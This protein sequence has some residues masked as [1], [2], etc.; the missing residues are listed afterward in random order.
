MPG[1]LENNLRRAYLQ[2]E[3][4]VYLLRT[5]AAVATIERPQD[6]GIDAIATLLRQS[7]TRKLIAEDTFFVQLKAG[8][9]KEVV[10]DEAQLTWYRQLELPYFI[11]SV[12]PQL[13]ELS[14]Y[15]CFAID[16]FFSP[17]NEAQSVTLRL[18]KAN[19]LSTYSPVDVTRVGEP[20][21]VYLGEPL[22]RFGLNE[23]QQTDFLARAHAVLK[24]YLQLQRANIQTRNLNIHRGILWQTNNPAFL[25][26]GALSSARSADELRVLF[27]DLKPR[28]ETLLMTAE[29]ALD[30][31]LANKVR[32]LMEQLKARG[33]D[34]HVPPN[35]I[36]HMKLAHLQLAALEAATTPPRPPQ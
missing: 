21:I 24:P 12:D 6:F 1:T 32:T 3:L 28:L 29:C 26:G 4:G 23:G 7:T 13:A 22:L 36:E 27:E 20:G 25:S 10:F 17:N 9:V 5:F 11:G 31:E 34:V 19:A 18:E 30:A 8:S 35:L 14:L 33:L 15:P 16:K 2:E